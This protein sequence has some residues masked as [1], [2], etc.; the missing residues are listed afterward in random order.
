M[1]RCLAVYLVRRSGSCERLGRLS[2]TEAGVAAHAASALID[3][4]AAFH[5]INEYFGKKLEYYNG[6]LTKLNFLHR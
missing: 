2:L 1:K 3:A 4:P 5:Q 6:F